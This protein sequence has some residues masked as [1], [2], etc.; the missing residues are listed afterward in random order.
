MGGEGVLCCLAPWLQE[1]AEACAT[2]C[3]AVERSRRRS[4]FLRGLRRAVWRHSSSAGGSHPAQ[5]HA[6]R[7]HGHHQQPQQH[8]GA[9]S[10]EPSQSFQPR[11]AA[12]FRAADVRRPA[13]SSR[14]DACRRQVPVHA[15][16]T[17]RSGSSAAGAPCAARARA[18]PTPR[19]RTMR[20]VVQAR[21]RV[22]SW[23]SCS[24]KVRRAA[25]RHAHVAACRWA[26]ARS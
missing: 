9:G 12:H 20:A 3:N 14:C 13:L 22:P 8:A 2:P 11:T 26:R 18:P 19:Q 23:C 16:C 7:S 5:G 24:C 17:P 15:R 10:R 6:Q 25:G 21:T 4:H 1:T